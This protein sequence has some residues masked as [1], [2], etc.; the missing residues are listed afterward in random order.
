MIHNPDFALISYPRMLTNELI[1]QMYEI[2]LIY[3]N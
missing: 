1:P 2:F 3:P